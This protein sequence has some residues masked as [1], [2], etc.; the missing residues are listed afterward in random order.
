MKDIAIFGAGGFGREIA[1]LIKLINKDV[2]TW[3]MIGY[4]DDNPELKGKSNEYGEI[5]GGTDVLNTWRSPLS[6]L[7]AIGSG[8]TV[9]KI[10]SRINNLFVEYPNFF[11]K[12]SFSDESNIRLGKGNILID[13]HLSCA[14]TM[15]DFNIMNG[16]VVFGHDA[17]IGNYNTFMPGTRISGEVSVGDECFFGVGSIVLQQLK[18][19]NR[20]KL[21]AGSVLM[22]KPKSDSVYIGNP[23]KIFYF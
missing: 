12:P 22:T 19:G 2:P 10:V 8:A 7:M 13:S 11:F 4:F 21:G 1:C 17:V 16:G 15:G 6:V 14:V 9:K 23:A 5:L 3:N 18:I 20:V